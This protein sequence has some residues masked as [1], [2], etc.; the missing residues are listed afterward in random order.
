MKRLRYLWRVFNYRRR[1]NRDEIAFL[2]NKIRPG[3]AAVDVGA[4]KGGFLYWLRHHVGPTGQ[5]YG[6]EPQPVLARYLEE[7]VA[8]QGWDNVTIEPAGLSSRSG[9]MDLFVPA[10]GGQPSP[11]AS[12]SPADPAAPHYSVQVPVV[13]LD[14]Y[15]RGRTAP[16]VTF[17]KCDCEGHE[18]EVFRGAE[19][20]LR[21]DHPVL[22]FECEQ[23]HLPGSSPAVVFDYLKSLGYR[24]YFF[25]PDGLAP[26][27][28]FSVARHQPARP[29]RFWDE[30]DYFNNFA[31]VPADE[32]SQ[33]RDK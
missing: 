26:I 5:V 8:M 4:H 32:D 27:D 22:L 12:L 3:D 23:R 21:R 19:S 30:K 6:F 11:G 18:L 9:K 29:G 7:I 25:G 17:I 13:T 20:L 16:R 15:F 24:G 33:R 14:D 10:T 1:V 2:A 28:Q 31:F